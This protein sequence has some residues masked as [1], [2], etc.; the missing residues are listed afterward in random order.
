[1]RRHYLFFVVFL[2]LAAS[3]QDWQACKP[4]GGY[5]FNDV[6]ATIQNVSFISLRTLE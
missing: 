1:M 3:A 2:A 6:K 5:S 4:E